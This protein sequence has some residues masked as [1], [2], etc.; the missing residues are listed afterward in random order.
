[1]KP[2]A[3]DARD[4]EHL[5]GGLLHGLHEVGVVDVTRPLPAQ[6]HQQHVGAGEVLHVVEHGAHVGMAHRDQ[7]EEAG[8]QLDVGGAPAE[9]HRDEG[10]Q[11]RQ[12]V[13]PADQHV[14]ETLDEAIQ[15]HGWPP[16]GP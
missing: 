5:V 2:R 8:V 9:K 3:V 16:A 13:A 7:L 12:Q 14:G 11:D 6:V 10:K 1:L 4:Q 15:A